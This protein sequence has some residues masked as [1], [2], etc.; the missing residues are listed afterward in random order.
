M[1]TFA[2]TLQL[3]CLSSK[4]TVIKRPS[5][6]I[7]NAGLTTRLENVQNAGRMP[8]GS[9]KHTRKQNGTTWEPH[10][11]LTQNG[12][13]CLYTIFMRR[14]GLECRSPANCDY[15]TSKLCCALR[16]SLWRPNTGEEEQAY[17]KTQAVWVTHSIRNACFLSL[18]ISR[19]RKLRKK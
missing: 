5:R 17:H 19:N 10:R 3:W 4:L 13:V 11:N 15:R 14:I 8:A 16:A 18:L 2:Y 12:R 6:R 9:G 7:N 1:S